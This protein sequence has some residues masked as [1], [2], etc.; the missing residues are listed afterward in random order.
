MSLSEEKAAEPLARIPDDTTDP[1]QHPTPPLPNITKGDRLTTQHVNN[2]TENTSRE[3]QSTSVLAPPEG[4]DSRMTAVSSNGNQRRKC[5][6]S[7]NHGILPQTVSDLNMG[8][9]SHDYAT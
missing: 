4:N 8:H 1:D 9:S 2:D 3:K 6:I 5:G 7:G